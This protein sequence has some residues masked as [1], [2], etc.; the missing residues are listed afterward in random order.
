[1]ERMRRGET[2]GSWLA[3]A[4]PQLGFPVAA[5]GEAVQVKSVPGGSSAAKAGLIAGDVLE[6]IDGRSVRTTD[7]IRQILA[8][9]DPGQQVGVQANR[10][11]QRVEAKIT[12]QPRVP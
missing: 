9:Y 8:D 3:G 10:R 12:L 6:Q 2:F 1:M 7:D 4:E 11:N 5:E